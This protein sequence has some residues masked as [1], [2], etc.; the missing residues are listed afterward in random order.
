MDLDLRKLR[1]FAAVADRLH[2]TRAAE[3]LH[4]A[5]PVL[6]RQIRALEHD[7]GAELFVRD[8]HGVTLTRAGQQLLD[9][10]RPLLAS[11][12]AARRRVLR[13]ARGPQHLVVG[14]RSGIVVTD[15][16]RAFTAAH[17]EVTVG[18]QRLEWDDQAEVLLDGRVDIAFVILPIDERGL[19]VIPLFREPRLAALPTGHR[20][21]AKE[22]LTLADL[23][24]EPVIGHTHHVGHGTP[25]AAGAIVVRSV[26]EKLEHVASGRAITFLPASA[27]GYYTRPDIVYVPVTDAPP[28]EV[29][30]AYDATR[31]SSLIGD[32]ARVANV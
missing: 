6:S 30:L 27:T 14:F 29:C 5:Q 2:F 23:A 31:T 25:L 18:V 7:L 11:A 17:P 28:D 13:A 12:E 10:A 26:E 8:S 24:A 19:E 3:D 32:F 15:A 22:S 1:Y 16:V 9:D 20:L 21:A 4:I